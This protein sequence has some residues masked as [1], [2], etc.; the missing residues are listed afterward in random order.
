MSKY[1]VNTIASMLT[2][3]PNVF[4]ENTSGANENITGY[5]M[6][7]GSTRH[8][9][10]P[11]QLMGDPRAIHNE[12][13]LISRRMEDVFYGR[14]RNIIAPKTGGSSEYGS[15]NITPQNSRALYD[16]Y[17]EFDLALT[18]VMDYLRTNAHILHLNH[19]QLN[20]YERL[21]KTAMTLNQ[22]EDGRKFYRI[23]ASALN[24]LQENMRLLLMHYESRRNKQGQ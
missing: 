16:M 6:P 14:D 23:N 24:N 20:E 4:M 3:D 11:N 10:L 7:S 2:E 22:D 1:N 13:S 12:L 19:G 21:Y 8:D 5:E 17:I 9:N 15:F 18:K